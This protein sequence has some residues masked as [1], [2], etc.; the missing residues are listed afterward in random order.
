ML[1]MVVCYTDT[2][3]MSVKDLMTTGS[4]CFRYLY[5]MPSGRTEEVGFVFSITCF[6]VW[7]KRRR[8]VVL[9]ALLALDFVYFLVG[10]SCGSLVMDA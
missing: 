10:G 4:S 7:G 5:E 1:G 2:S 3:R 9:G 8:G 6:V